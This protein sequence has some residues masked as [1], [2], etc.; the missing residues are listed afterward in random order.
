MP[1][2]NGTLTDA[3]RESLLA[4]GRFAAPYLVLGVSALFLAAHFSKHGF[5]QMDD[6]LTRDAVKRATGL[7]QLVLD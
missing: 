7:I 4:M 1:N 2:D 5:G 6:G 3:E